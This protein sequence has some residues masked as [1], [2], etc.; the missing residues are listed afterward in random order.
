MA[1]IMV[2][3]IAS[4]S[5]GA[6]I[7]TS[8]TKETTAST[9]SMAVKG[10][11]KASQSLLSKE[12]FLPRVI[13]LLPYRRRICSTATSCKPLYDVFR[14]SRTAVAL[15]LDATTSLCRATSSLAISI[16]VLYSVIFLVIA[17]TSPPLISRTTT[18]WWKQRHRS[19]A[20]PPQ[21]FVSR[22]KNR[23]H[24]LSICRSTLVLLRPPR[25]MS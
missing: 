2:T 23:T 16:L 1:R 21:I 13:L 12:S 22:Q 4:F 11:T 14:S 6:A 17:L 8:V 15:L 20:K 25:P 9:K 24:C 10:L 19:Q 3:V 18:S 7:A 5:L